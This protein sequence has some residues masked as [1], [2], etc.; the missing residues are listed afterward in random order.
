[1]I[2]DNHKSYKVQGTRYKVETSDSAKR[3]TS[4]D[5]RCTLKTGYTLIELLIVMFIFSVSMGILM[6]TYVSFIRLSHKTANAAVLQQDARYLMEFITRNVRDQSLDYASGIT[7]S[8][9]TLRIK[10][11]DS[12]Y[13]IIKLASAGDARCSDTSGAACALISS[14]NGVNWAPLTSRFVNVDQMKFYIQPTQTPFEI[15][16][17]AGNYYNNQQPLVTVYLRLTYLAKNVKERVSLE[18]QTSVSLKSY[19]R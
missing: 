11:G 3:C 10:N 12:S 15:N 6:Q 8:S 4:H 1:M 2:G 5:V 9:S 14:D 17:M 13:L 7:V 18:A 16:P 19:V